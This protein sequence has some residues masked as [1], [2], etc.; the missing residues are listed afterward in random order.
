MEDM[1]TY[2][3]QI[4]PLNDEAKAALFELA[5]V[6]KYSKNELILEEG[7][8]CNK[9]WFLKSGMVRKFYFHEGKEKTV[10]IHTENEIFTSLQ[11]SGQRRPA[12]ECLEACE[13]SKTIS[14]SS[15]NSEML[16]R[17]PALLGMSPET[18]SRIRKL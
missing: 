9:I 3:E 5:N 17:F 15:E 13:D 1:V 4:V 10:W 18:L 7:Q 16:I 6:K 12:E 2:I 8:R 11:C 14:I